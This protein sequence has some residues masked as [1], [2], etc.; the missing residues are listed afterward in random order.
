MLVTHKYAAYTYYLPYH[1]IK[2][3]LE[4]QMRMPL[5]QNWLNP[6]QFDLF[7]ND[8][9]T[10]RQLTLNVFIIIIHHSTSKHI[11]VFEFRIIP[12]N[13]NSTGS[14]LLFSWKIKTHLSY[15]DN[16]AAFDAP[17][18]RKQCVNSN[19]IDLVLSEYSR[20]N[21]LVKIINNK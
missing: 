17:R 9:P 20:Y 13:W 19:F 2:Y 14:I 1:Y 21:C 16:T 7:F 8:R 12:L 10:G 18:R 11:H 3:K 5:C 6:S 4:T 15:I